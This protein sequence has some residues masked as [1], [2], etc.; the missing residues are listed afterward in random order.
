MYTVVVVV[1]YTFDGADHALQE[2]T[3]LGSTDSEVVDVQADQLCSEELVDGST[4]AVHADQELLDGSADELVDQAPQVLLDGSAV[5]LDVQAP[6]GSL[7]ELVVVVL[8]SADHEPQ[9]SEPTAE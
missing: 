9:P 8:L 5:E 7:A 4:L 1:T 3:E 6:H 2:V